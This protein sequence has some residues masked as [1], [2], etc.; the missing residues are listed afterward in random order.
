MYRLIFLLN[1]STESFSPSRDKN[2][3]LNAFLSSFSPCTG[4]FL[5]RLFFWSY[6][7]MLPIRFLRAGMPNFRDMNFVFMVA[8]IAAALFPSPWVPIQSRGICWG[9][10][11]K[12]VQES[13]CNVVAIFGALVYFIKLINIFVCDIK[14]RRR[15][16]SFSHRRTWNI[17][18]GHDA[19]DGTTALGGS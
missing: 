15:D 6:L 17:I 11:S 12:M 10:D 3:L 2:F 18:L 8:S 13:A 4:S 9:I 16:G 7:L 19:H 1:L 5:S 14:I